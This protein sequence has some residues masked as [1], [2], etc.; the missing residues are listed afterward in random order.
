[1][2]TEQDRL[3]IMRWETET[4]PTAG[5]NKRPGTRAIAKI[6]AEPLKTAGKRGSGKTTA[7][8][9]TTGRKGTNATGIAKKNAV[10]A[11][12]TG[13]KPLLSPARSG[14]STSNHT[15]GS[16]RRKAPA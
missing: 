4:G 10:S 8:A 9:T 15:Q 16:L 5:K 1:M 12:P 6:V 13:A 14:T 7:P 2:E 11:K 3:A